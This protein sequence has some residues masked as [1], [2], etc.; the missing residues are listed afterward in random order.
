MIIYCILDHSWRI[1]KI[2]KQKKHIQRECFKKDLPH[3]PTRS[4]MRTLVLEYLPRFARTK[5]SSF[6]GKYTSTM[7]HLGIIY[8]SFSFDSICQNSPCPLKLLYF[9]HLPTIYK[10]IHKTWGKCRFFSSSFQL[11]GLRE[12][13]QENAIFHRKIYG[14]L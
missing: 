4:H 5:S 3:L 14:F 12:K 7:E 10:S 11:I 13:I 8:F 9:P 1:V 2:Y 6:V